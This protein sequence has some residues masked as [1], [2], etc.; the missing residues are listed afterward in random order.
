ME[1]RCKNYSVLLVSMSKGAVS[2]FYI[3]HTAEK[4]SANSIRGAKI[5]LEIIYHAK[6]NHHTEKR[7]KRV[8]GQ[9]HS[10]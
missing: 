3:L 7:S 9:R 6:K 2:F 10:T 5:Y 8:T 4:Y 1:S